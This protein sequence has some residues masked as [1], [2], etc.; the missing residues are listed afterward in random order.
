MEIEDVME[1]VQL[2]DDDWDSAVLL[3]GAVRKHYEIICY[4]CAC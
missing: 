2:A 3:N 1:W 4:H